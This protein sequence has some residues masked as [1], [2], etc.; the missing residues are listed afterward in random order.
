MALCKRAI[1][2]CSRAVC[3]VSVFSEAH[4]FEGAFDSQAVADFGGEG[5]RDFHGAEVECIGDADEAGGGG[6]FDGEAGEGALDAFAVGWEVDGDFGALGSEGG[7][8]VG[9]GDGEID[10]FY[11]AG[12]GDVGH[13]DADGVAV[14]LGSEFADEDAADERRGTA[15]AGERTEI[16]VHAAAD[17][18]WIEAGAADV[19]ADAI[20][21][22]EID[23]LKGEAG[24]EFAGA[25]QE[26]A[27]AGFDFAGGNDF[28][29]GSLV[30]LIFE[31]GD[32]AE[33]WGFR[34]GDA[35]HVADD[36]FMA[37]AAGGAVHR[38]GADFFAETDD[39]HFDKAAAEGAEEIGVGFDAVDEDDVVGLEGGDACEH[40]GAAFGDADLSDFHRGADGRGHGGFGD[41]VGG[42]DFGLAF[43]CG[44]AVAAH[45]GED[46][47][48]RAG[49]AE[50]VEG[51]A[52]DCRDVRN[53]A[54]ADTD[55]DDVGLLYGFE[56]RRE[57]LFQHRAKIE[58]DAR[59]EILANAGHFRKRRH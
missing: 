15:L 41:A 2:R 18:I 12:G 58:R 22:E 52:D 11:E 6:V 7:E 33:H 1:V 59:G 20:D 39:G 35:G 23:F 42:E 47:G 14:G 16:A 36:A 26:R 56:E 34:E 55:S 51:C 28:E 46:E 57:L 32:A 29:G 38:F 30:I 45:G 24:H 50:D 10:G 9:V 5:L 25:F 54:T 3:E 53:A 8:G 49:G 48:L 44:A 4:G 40:A 17:D 37:E 43:G 21:D 27:L 19:F 31:D 13:A